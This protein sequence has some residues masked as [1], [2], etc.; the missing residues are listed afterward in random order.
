MVAFDEKGNDLALD[1]E[2]VAMSPEER[3]QTEKNVRAF[4]DKI[5]PTL[6]PRS[7]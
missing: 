1:A 2:L 5:R 7:R 3:A 6:R 4:I